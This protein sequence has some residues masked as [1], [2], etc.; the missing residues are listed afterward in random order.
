MV[1]GRMNLR[2]NFSKTKSAPDSEEHTW[3][4][5]L[6]PAAY[7]AQS[8]LVV[9]PLYCWAHVAGATTAYPDCAPSGDSRVGSS[10]QLCRPQT[11]GAN[12]R[13]EHEGD[14]VG[15]GASVVTGV[16]DD[17]ADDVNSSAGVHLGATG[18]NSQLVGG[19]PVGTNTHSNLMSPYQLSHK[20]YYE[21][22]TLGQ[23][24]FTQSASRGDNSMWKNQ[25]LYERRVNDERSRETATLQQPYVKPPSWSTRFRRRDRPALQK[26][27]NI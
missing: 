4:E 21:D 24:E 2:I 9:I 11:N 26:A 6:P 15:E 1:T 23:R 25:P 27:K 8:I 18:T 19:E 7:P 3:Q 17:L 13:A 12:I 5:S 10:C 20:A 22:W 16:V 14:V